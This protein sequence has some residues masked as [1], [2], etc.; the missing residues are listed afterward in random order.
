MRRSETFHEEIEMEAKIETDIE[1]SPG[2]LLKVLQRRMNRTVSRSSLFRWRRTLGFLEPPFYIDHVEA[3]EIY[4]N[5]LGLGLKPDV[6]KAKTEEQ[7]EL[8]YSFK[9][10]ISNGTT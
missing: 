10:D 9:E 1:L 3:L 8:R 7:I 4:G 6:A 5:L 2:G